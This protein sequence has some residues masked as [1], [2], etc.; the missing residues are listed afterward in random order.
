MKDIDKIIYERKM[1]YKRLLITLNFK[2]GTVGFR[3]WVNALEFYNSNLNMME[4]YKKIAAQN[5]VSISIVEMAMRKSKESAKMN[6]R[7]RYNY[8]GKL[9]NSA[10]LYLLKEV[11]Y[12]NI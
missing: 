3:Y 11:D 7:K 6:I 2:V 9:S 1:K 4:I 8:S 10:V 12:E 5:N